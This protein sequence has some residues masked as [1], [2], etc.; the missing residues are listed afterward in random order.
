M[1]RQSL[2]QYRG[3]K[4]NEQAIKQEYQRN[5][6]IG[7]ELNCWKSGMLVADDQGKVLQRLQETSG[8]TLDD[9]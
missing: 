9:Q 3:W 8:N 4:G 5:F 2:E 1:G 7:K 6:E